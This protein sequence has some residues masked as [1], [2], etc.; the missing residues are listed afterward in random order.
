LEAT[1]V[2]EKLPVTL[3]LT[4]Y[5]LPPQNICNATTRMVLDMTH[6]WIN[7]D[8]FT[9]LERYPQLK[10]IYLPNISCGEEEL[11]IAGPNRII[12]GMRGKH[13]N[14]LIQDIQQRCT[15]ARLE[16][17]KCES[18]ILRGM[19]V[20]IGNFCFLNMPPA[21]YRYYGMGNTISIT[22]SYLYMVR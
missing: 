6:T 16:R 17:I 4:C 19:T 5:D 7:D 12:D 20:T 13:D 18:A 10:E 14:S 22:G 11:I 9:P 21:E 2:E 1:P 3:H 8:G 15:G